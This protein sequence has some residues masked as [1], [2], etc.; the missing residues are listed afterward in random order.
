MRPVDAVQLASAKITDDP[1]ILGVAKGPCHEAI[2]VVAS[3]YLLVGSGLPCGGIR[4]RGF[5]CE[6]TGMRD[7]VGCTCAVQTAEMLLPIARTD[8]GNGLGAI[9]DAAF[10]DTSSACIA[11]DASR[12]SLRQVAWR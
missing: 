2:L 8:M 11:M 12:L 3:G 10:K 5:E 1:R 6:C 7:K 4:T 9:Q